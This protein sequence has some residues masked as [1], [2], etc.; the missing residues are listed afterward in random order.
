M[1][2]RQ[3]GSFQ[4]RYS[5]TKARLNAFTHELFEIISI[6]IVKMSFIFAV[7]I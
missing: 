7:D 3:S 1:I 6:D 4:C 2:S 5:L